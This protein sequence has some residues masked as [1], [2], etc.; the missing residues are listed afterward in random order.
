M[1]TSTA[2]LVFHFLKRPLAVRS[3]FFP[4]FGDYMSPAFFFFQEITS[5]I[6]SFF[7]LFYLLS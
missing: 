4:C 7:F 5:N 1:F 2:T 6:L 3:V